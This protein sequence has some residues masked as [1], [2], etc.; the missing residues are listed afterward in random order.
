MRPC[1]GVSHSVQHH[2]HGCSSRCSLK[3]RCCL[4]AC[5][6]VSCHSR[7]RRAP[8]AASSPS[9]A[10]RSRPL[11]TRAAPAAAW[12][13]TS[14]IRKLHLCTPSCPCASSEL[15]SPCATLTGS[16]AFELL[17]NPRFFIVPGAAFFVHVWPLTP[18]SRS[19]AALLLRLWSLICDGSCAGL[20]W[21][22]STNA[23]QVSDLLG[24]LSFARLLPGCS[25]AHPPVLA[26]GQ[27]IR[28]V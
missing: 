16:L 11:G 7:K 20:T 13:R 24:R 25:A 28:C 19:I 5:L 21:K 4:G 1:A 17:P 23:H 8:C 3:D 12:S 10:S 6:P 2:S 26:P 14:P 15:R 27:H 22:G 9:R 18:T